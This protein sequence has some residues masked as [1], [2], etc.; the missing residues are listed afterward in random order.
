MNT[1]EALAEGNPFAGAWILYRMIFGP[2][3]WPVI[4]ANAAGLAWCVWKA[5]QNLPAWLFS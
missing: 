3:A 5:A 2:L 4:L 1:D